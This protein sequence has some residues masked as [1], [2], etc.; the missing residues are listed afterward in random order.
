MLAN[1]TAISEAWTRLNVKF[2]LMYNKRAF[3]HWYVGEGMEEGEFTEAR[4]NL[5]ALEKDFEEI[6]GDTIGDLGE[7]DEEEF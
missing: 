4:E 3:V 5:A 7:D 2:D 1:T 6:A